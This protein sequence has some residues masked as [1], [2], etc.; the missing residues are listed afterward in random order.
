MKKTDIERLKYEITGLAVLEI[1][2]MHTDVSLAAVIKQL[3]LMQASEIDSTR[4]ELIDSVINDFTNINPGKIGIK[5]EKTTDESAFSA[6][7]NP[8]LH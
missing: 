6:S 5:P 4:K 2:R 8:K 7:K 3:R 1:L